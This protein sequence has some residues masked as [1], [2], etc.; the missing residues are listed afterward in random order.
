MLSTTVAPI[1]TPANDLFARLSV[2]TAEITN[3]KLKV[4]MNSTMNVAVLEPEGRV[5]TY[6]SPLRLQTLLF[7]WNMSLRASA[8]KVDPRS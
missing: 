8:A 2:A 3:N 7:R 4:A 6:T 1:A 5:P